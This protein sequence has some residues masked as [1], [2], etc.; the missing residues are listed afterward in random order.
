MQK[1]V[2]VRGAGRV[3]EQEWRW[4][5]PIVLLTIGFWLVPLTHT[6][7]L[8]CVP[9]DLGDARFNG[10][11]LE[12]IYRW[13]TG[14]DASLI[15]PPFFFPMPGAL[16]FSDNHLGTGWLYSLYRFLGA[17][18]YQAFDL[19]YLSGF[20][21]N[22]IACHVVLRKFGF[23]PIASALGAFA[24]SFAMPAIA[25]HGHA[26][27]GYRFLV[28]VALLFWQKFRLTG[29]WHWLGL[30]ALAVSGQFYLSIYIGY[31]LVFML[32]AW[33]GAQALVERTWPWTWLASSQSW[34]EPS[35]RRDLLAAIVMILVALAALAWLMYPYLH[36]AKLYGFQRDSSEIA[37]M[38]PRL[39][40]YL[41]ADWSVI[42]EKASKQLVDG[43]PMRH[44]HQLFF[45]LGIMGLALIGVMKS[46][47]QIRWVALL[48][49]LFLVVLTLSVAEKS[50]Y[51][52]MTGLPGANSIRAVT[53]IGLVMAMP[54]AVLVA[55]GVDAARGRGFFWEL[56]I[57]ALALVMVAESASTRTVNFGIVQAREGTLALQRQ[58]PDPWPI[59]G[60]L[61]VAISND[62]E[63]PSSYTELDGMELAQAVGRPTLNGYSGN[64]AP[65]YAAAAANPPCTQGA[66]RLRAAAAFYADNLKEP[67]PEGANGPVV[68]AGHPECSNA[69]LAPLPLEDF[70][71]VTLEVVAVEPEGAHYRVHAIVDNQSSYVLDSA[72]AAQPMR[73]SWQELAV[74][75]SI[76]PA[77][78]RPRVE[79][80]QGL[81][82]GPGERRE[83]QFL[84]PA[85]GDDDRLAVSM[86]I[87]GR[88]WFHD[89]GVAPVVVS[90]PRRPSGH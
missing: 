7:Y 90:L 36:Y 88:A 78:W 66:R 60:M 1:D 55:V 14:G 34:R 33:G 58:L 35:G 56:L 48:S 6:C 75:A 87:E 64:V 5:A 86:V 85:V 52:L 71:K 27:L 26:Q 19:W 43:I 4:I 77:A 76:D 40:S 61:F 45:G 18:R 73:L 53:R 67:L 49:L 21:F 84:V 83:V 16:S 17:D 13:L 44:E 79:I 70:P 10:V 51:L 9:G 24:F 31:F 38:L 32:A 62:T 12:H 65:G 39:S 89:Q 8:A 47:L 46:S 20:V 80:S 50:L 68:V 37:T 29:R 81:D 82:L 41:L 57:G 3:R 42:W 11:I 72:T 28:P 15:S 69:E 2:A 22:Y 23:S 74:G 25:Q 59:N 54:A 63:R 30:L